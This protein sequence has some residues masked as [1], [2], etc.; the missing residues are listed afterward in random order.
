MDFEYSDEQ[1]LLAETLRK[2]LNTGY[3]FDARAKIVAG[4]A[5]WSE[6]VWAVLADE[7]PAAGLV[8]S[9]PIPSESP[10]P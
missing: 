7:W 3:G 4:P 8:D 6:D 10:R 1:K 2:F 9:P 5:G